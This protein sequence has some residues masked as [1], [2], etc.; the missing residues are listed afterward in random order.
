MHT[1]PHGTAFAPKKWLFQREAMC[2][3]SCKIYSPRWCRKRMYQCGAIKYSGSCRAVIGRQWK[4]PKFCAPQSPWYSVC[5]KAMVISKGSYV[6]GELKIVLPS[7]VQKTYLPA[8]GR[9]VYQYMGIVI[10]PT[11]LSVQKTYLPVRGRKEIRFMKGGIGP[12]ME[13]CERS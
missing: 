2:L 4:Y 5:T 8:Q 7:S 13:I 6:Y 3:G 9:K 10:G 11:P 1:N 12:T